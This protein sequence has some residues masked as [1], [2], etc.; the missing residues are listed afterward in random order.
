M[1]PT[2]LLVLPLSVALTLTTTQSA[3]ARGATTAG[4]TR[5]IE[6]ALTTRGEAVAS[7]EDPA[8]ATSGSVV[9]S[10]HSSS[11]L[12]VRLPGSATGAAAVGAMTVNAT[13]GPG[14]RTAVQETGEGSF[15]A[16]VYVENAAAPHEYRFDLGES[17]R[18]S[19]L[20]DGGVMVR[21][22]QGVLLGTFAPPWATDASGVPVETRYRLAGDSV[23]QVITPTSA[24]RFPVIADPW[25]IP[26][27]ILARVMLG[28]MTKHAARQAAV[29]KVGPAL[30]RQIIRDGKATRG[31]G[32]TTVFS[33]GKGKNHIRVVVDNK[34]GN[35]ITITKG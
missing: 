24:T 15:R 19:L 32:N 5:S 18:A 30:V 1:R 31:R 34:S 22:S 14:Y 35:V 7:L 9:R 12:S 2:L 6:S 28:V 11:D 23:V 4:M 26:L 13:S 33:Q 29:R 20:P 10:T 21:D 3:D 25:W 27:I 8:V 17:R 16:L